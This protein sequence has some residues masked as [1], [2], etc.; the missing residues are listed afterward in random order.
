MKLYFVGLLILIV[1]TVFRLI[2]VLLALHAMKSEEIQQGP[3]SKLMATMSQLR[4]LHYLFLLILGAC[5]ASEL[6]GVAR[7]VGNSTASLTAATI[8]IFEPIAAFAFL[9]FAAFTCLHALEWFVSYRVEAAR[10]NAH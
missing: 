8:E 5:F 4:R 6:F 3:L 9:A 10:L 7:A 1:Y 2:K